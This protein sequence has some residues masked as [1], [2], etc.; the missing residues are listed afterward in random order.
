MARVSHDLRTPLNSIIG[1]TRIVLRRM[2][3]KVPDLQK[4]NLHKVLISGEHLL[5]LINTLLDLA[6]IESGRMEVVAESF[7]VDDAIHMAATTVEPLLKDGRVRLVRDI[8]PGLPPI[9][10]DRDK[11]KQ[12]LLNLLE[13]RR[14]VYRARRDPD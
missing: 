12:I 11:L 9:K 7:R 1:F 2:E 8:A 10:T 4:D 14:Q 3:G 5:G 13:Q 6:K